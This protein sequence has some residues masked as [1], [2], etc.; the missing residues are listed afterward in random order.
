MGRRM[1]NHDHGGH[2]HHG[3]ANFNRAFI[4]GI[5][6]NGA[7]I[8]LE[9]GIG[10]AVGSLALLADAG[11]NLSDV[12]GLLLAWTGHYL[13]SLKP[14]GRYT[15]GFRSSSIMAALLNALI[16]L[17]AIGGILWEA[18]RRFQE[19]VAVEGQAV[20]WV[21]TVG[22][23]INTL[24]ALLFLRGS[25]GDINI[26]GAF[27]HMAADAG[28]SLGVVLAGV[29]ILLTK[30]T[31]IDPAISILVAIVIFIGTWDLL[32][33]A[34]NL[35]LQAVPRGIDPEKV[36][37]YLENLPGV[38]G[39]HDLHIWPMSTAE[40]ALTVHLLR[41]EISNDDQFLAETAK[42]LHD[43]FGIEHVTIQLERSVWTNPCKQ[44]GP[45]SV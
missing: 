45:N 16:L 8:L 37:I 40:T 44:S 28:V 25:R 43:Q 2:H 23:V 5:T 42:G 12:L 20:I 32:R 17:V 15:Y 30:W 22:V 18:V 11:H 26:R 41:P 14:T 36:Q 33:E 10:L 4:I 38:E 29:G 3:P 6:L 21:A 19:P 39:L 24:T 1:H 9:F 31:W 7:Y 34:I 35:S 13:S 27:L